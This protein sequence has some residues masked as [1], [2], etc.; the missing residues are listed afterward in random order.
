[1]FDFSNIIF[2]LIFFIGNVKLHNGA[3]YK[4]SEALINPYTW[5]MN[6]TITN[7]VKADFGAY[8]CTSVNA[9]GKEDARIRLQGI[10]NILFS[11]NYIIRN[12][13]RSLFAHS[14]QFF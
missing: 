7:L 13:S 3:K 14:P 10:F 1:M 4:I 2:F 5:Q 9:L 11:K 8:T 6:L 12:I